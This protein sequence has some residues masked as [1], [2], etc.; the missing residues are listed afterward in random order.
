M[1]HLIQTLILIIPLILPLTAVCQE[2]NTGGKIITVENTFGNYCDGYIV[3]L[4]ND[5][6]YGTIKD[7]FHNNSQ[8][9]SDKVVLKDN[10][11]KKTTYYPTEIKGYCKSDT[12][13]YFTVQD[14]KKK[15]FAKLIVDGELKLL[16]IHKIYAQPYPM[17]GGAVGSVSVPYTAYF[18]NNKSTG[19][20]TK[21]IKKDFYRVMSV[22]FSDCEPLSEVILSKELGYKDIEIIVDRYNKCKAEK[23]SNSQPTNNSQ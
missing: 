11:G 23:Y 17:G 1:K 5:T 13:Y 10:R 20:I 8:L 2:N 3:T 9:A 22:Y 4:K 6:I 21:V 7:Q 14:G 16:K 12:E 19:K 15:S 18:L